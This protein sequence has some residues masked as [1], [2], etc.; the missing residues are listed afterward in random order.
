M[1][2]LKKYIIFKTFLITRKKLGKKQEKKEVNNSLIRK[3]KNKT[4]THYRPYIQRME[5]GGSKTQIHM[6]TYI[7]F[8]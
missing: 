4:I 1:L 7:I 6:T 3:I 5:M 2:H 8:I